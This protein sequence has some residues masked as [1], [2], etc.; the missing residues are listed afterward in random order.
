[1]SSRKNGRK[2]SDPRQPNAGTLSPVPPSLPGAVATETDRRQDG[3]IEQAILS[4]RVAIALG[5]IGTAVAVWSAVSSHRAVGV[6]EDANRI[7][8]QSQDRAAGKVTAKF[9]VVGDK[10]HDQ[11]A[12][13][14]LIRKKDGYDELVLRFES[15]DELVR[16]GPH[17]RVKNTGTEPID[18]IKVEIYQERGVAYGKGVFQIYPPPQIHNEASSHEA[19]G[20]GKLMPNQTAKVLLNQL[21]L[22]QLALSKWKDFPDRDHEGTFSVRVWCRLVGSTSYDQV[23]NNKPKYLVFH[24]R[25]SGFLPD[26]KNVKEALDV[27]PAV[28]IE[29]A[30]D[31]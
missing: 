2:Q 6:A 24:W 25:P 9:E 20:F 12:I 5:L 13:K 29:S 19:T 31:K 28:R 10:N 23:E 27:K 16:W 3:R 18:A 17:V 1:M 4:S 15:V 22:Q 7:A 8:Q 14:D 21:V 11:D 30:T 26:A